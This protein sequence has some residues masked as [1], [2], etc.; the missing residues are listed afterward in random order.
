MHALRV[1]RRQGGSCEFK[2]QGSG[3]VGVRISNG[4]TYNRVLKGGCETGSGGKSRVDLPPLVL[5]FFITLGPR[6]S[7]SLSLSGLE[8]SEKSMC[9]R[10]E[11]SSE[12]FPVRTYRVSMTAAVGG[13]SFLDKKALNEYSPHTKANGQLITPVSVP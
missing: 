2:V 4:N 13:L 9:L 6:V 1:G 12:P 3:R 7:D 5:F 11:P 8:V 10:Y